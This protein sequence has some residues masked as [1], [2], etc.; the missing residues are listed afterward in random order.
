MELK[1]FDELRNTKD[2][3]VEQAKM[4]YHGSCQNLPKISQRERIWGSPHEHDEEEIGGSCAS[5]RWRRLVGQFLMRGGLA[6]VPAG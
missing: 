3:M 5:Q 6:R 2:W 4:P 1:K